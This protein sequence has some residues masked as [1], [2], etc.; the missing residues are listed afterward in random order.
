MP[1]DTTAYDEG[2]PKELDPENQKNT[3][4]YWKRWI[5]AAEKAAQKHWQDAS[6]AWDEYENK[7]RSA[8]N[9]ML[10]NAVESGSRIYWASCKII[11]PALY[12]TTPKIATEREFGVNDMPALAACKIA[13]GLGKHH[14]GTSRVT[15]SRF[16]ECMH[17]AVQEFI[18]ADKACIQIIYEKKQ[19]AEGNVVEASQRIYPVSLAYNK[20]LHSPEAANQYDI[21]EKAIYFFL[22]KADAINRFG[23]EKC[24]K[25]RWKSRSEAK[26]S[27]DAQ[28][29]TEDYL[30]HFVEGWECYD[31]ENRMVRW[32][33]DQCDE[34]LDEREDPDRYY[35]FWSTTDYIIGSKPRSSLYPTPVHTQLRPLIGQ[36]H[37]LSERIYDLVDAIR[38]RAL[39][40]GDED[41]VRA[42]D[43][44]G[45]SMFVAVASL[46]GIVEKG[47]LKN[48]VLFVPIRELVEALNT[49]IAIQQQFKAEFN[50]NFGTPDVIRGITDPLEAEGTNQQNL[51]VVHDRFRNVKK[52][53][54]TLAS[55]ALC[56]MIEI[57]V[58]VYSPEKIARICGLDF[59]P[60]NLKAAFGAGL[61]ILQDPEQNIIRIDIDTDSLTF[62]DQKRE[63]EE[64]RFISDL[65]T[66]SLQNIASMLSINPQAASIALKL[67]VDTLEKTSE[68]KYLTDEVKQAVNAFLQQAQQPQP[69]PPDYEMQKLEIEKQRLQLDAQKSQSS[70]QIKVMGLEQKSVKTELDSV[71]LQLETVLEQNKQ[72]LEAHAE[73]RRLTQEDAR[74]QIEAQKLA[75]EQTVQMFMMKIEA[76]TL[77]IKRTQA[78]VQTTETLMEET[79]LAKEVDNNKIIGMIEALKP[80]E[81]KTE[82]ISAQP[83]VN[84]NVD[85]RTQNKK[86]EA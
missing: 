27:P 16:D 60:E 67:L 58:Q 19:D 12:S 81:Q 61:A 68:G 18:H 57:S 66:S 85:M 83:P 11:E 37:L 33:S 77:E 72:Q 3:R 25:I 47:G 2:D 13:E 50:E 21:T 43:S 26:N 82:L 70:D 35:D 30:G 54:A 55:Q 32:Y 69:P 1:E 28:T 80:P 49:S 63:R 15:N 64:Q 36:L 45:D 53:V 23:E 38:P 22:S 78:Q 31:L 65:V 7:N 79:R 40:D 29:E 62:K 56:K 4:E 84:L 51:S 41:V 39:V 52:Q 75:L 73:A 74:I 10:T 9:D 24:K 34:F 42:L 76:M 46:Q 71:R 59:W 14:V 5:K 86:S 44:I 48:M 17:A 8:N 6:A 20:T